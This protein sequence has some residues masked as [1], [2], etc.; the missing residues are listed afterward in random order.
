MVVEGGQDLAN[1]KT[2][3][4]TNH[5]VPTETIVVGFD[6]GGLIALKSM[7]AEDP[8]FDGAIAA[9]TPAAGM[10]KNVDRAL[11]QNL[12]IEATLA[13][14]A[15]WGAPGDVRDEVTL[16]E[17][18]AVHYL[19]FQDVSARLFPAFDFVRRL[20]KEPASDQYFDPPTPGG[21]TLLWYFTLVLADL[22]RRLGGSVAESPGRTYTMSAQDLASVNSTIQLLELLNIPCHPADAPVCPLPAGITAEQFLTELNAMPPVIANPTVRARLAAAHDLTGLVNGPVI[23]LH[24]TI[25]Q[26]FPASGTTAYLDAVTASGRQQHVLRQFTD[27]RA[28]LCEFTPAQIVSTISAMRSW[29]ATG[30]RPAASD[31][32]FFPSQLGFSRFF[33]P[34]P[35]P[36]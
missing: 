19:G 21:R 26:L 10:T 25:D 13:W 35:W 34:G 11:V 30:I 6:M 14:P 5:C 9:C 28:G 36:F 20:L 3:F 2:V 31:N 15:S 22:E 12:A 7:E 17:I 33:N 23:T 24:T 29:L 16:A 4:R 1:L 32:T 8:I 18:Q 27:N